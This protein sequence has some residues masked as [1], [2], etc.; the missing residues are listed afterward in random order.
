MYR[1]TLLRRMLAET[2]QACEACDDGCEQANAEKPEPIPGF[3]YRTQRDA[4]QAHDLA[5]AQPARRD[6]P[7]FLAMGGP[8]PRLETLAR[9]IR[10]GRGECVPA[11]PDVLVVPIRMGDKIPQQAD[12][13]NPRPS[14]NPNPN[15]NPRPSP[16]PS[17]NPDPSPSPEPDPNRWMES[18]PPD[19]TLSL[20]LTI[21]LTA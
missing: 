1:G 20:A 4:A 21:T 17:L 2:C 16:D 5:A 10:H 7:K 9:L 19:L 13:V 18:V 3:S 11:G 6:E 8:G 12:E 14:R 15:P